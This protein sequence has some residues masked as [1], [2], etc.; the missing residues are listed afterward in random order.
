MA[1]APLITQIIGFMLMPV[2]ARLY[3]PEAFGLF[4]LFMAIIGPIGIFVCMGYEVSI[5]LPKNDKDAA[6]MFNICILITFIITAL[7]VLL[8]LVAA[9][10]LVNLLSAPVE[11]KM[12]LWLFP[13]F[14]ILGGL[15]SSFRYWNLRKKSFSSISLAN[16]TSTSFDKGTSILLGFSG[17]TS[18]ISLIISNLTDAFSRPVVLGI[19]ALKGN[20]GLFKDNFQWT[21][22]VSGINKYRKFPMYSLPT[23]LFARLT[24]DIP[25]YLLIYYFSQSVVGQYALGLKLLNIPMSLIG[26]SVGEV[27]FQRETENSESK[28]ELLTT[29][30]KR[31]VLLGL[32]PFLLIGIIGEEIFSFMFGANWSEAGIYAQ[33]F[34]FLIFIRFITTPANYLM[35]LFEKQEY[36]LLLNITTATV[37][38]ISIIIGGFLNNVY[39]SIIL[40][41]LTNGFAYGVFGFG[42]MRKAGI[43]YIEIFKIIKYCF[44]LFLPLG[45]LISFEKYIFKSSSVILFITAGIGSIVYYLIAI[46]H[47]AQLY[48]K[49]I[50]IKFIK[51]FIK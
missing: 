18:G 5:M 15:S 14:I 48:S 31:L 7:S 25:V 37:T 11:F 23:N 27:Y 1:S 50:D 32:L 34:S 41:S 42:F 2:I 40:I 20:A 3:T 33:F 35:I 49:V 16:I 17:F 22:M 8:V 43:T 46:R 47:D 39:I 9:D 13:L 45:I 51:R 21:K 30:Y 29:L 12:Y 28:S 36:S 24:G 4:S 10:S 6:V 26:N 38:I 19:K 44:L